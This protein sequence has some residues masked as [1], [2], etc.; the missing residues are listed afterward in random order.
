MQVEVITGPEIT[1]VNDGPEHTSK[2]GTEEFVKALLVELNKN[3]VWRTLSSL[4]DALH[5]A[6]QSLSFWLDDNPKVVRRAGATTGTIYYALS[7]RLPKEN[8][9]KEN[10]RNRVTKEE[11]GYALAMLHM[12]YFQFYKILKTYGLEISQVDPEA[13]SH[14]TSSLDDLESGLLLFSKKI[15]AS[16]EKL[17]KFS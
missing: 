2:I 7:E 5:V 13:F 9:K 10:S 3:K 14:F 6:P 16:I 4:A 1:V 17:P 11:E 15:K 12:T 8:S